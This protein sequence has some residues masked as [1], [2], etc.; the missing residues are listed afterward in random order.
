MNSD[1]EI[2]YKENNPNQFWRLF[3]SFKLDY[4]N[5]GSIYHPKILDYYFLRAA[6]N[7]YHLK[8]YS[9][10]FTFKDEPYSAFLGAEFTKNS[11]SNLNLFE[12]PCLAVDKNTISLNKKKK[13]KSF[14]EFIL[15]LNLKSFQIK[16]PE[17]E[18]KIPLLCEF[19]LSDTQ[20]EL[21]PYT[22]RIIDLRHNEID[23][24][25]TIRK[26][27]HSLINWGLNSMKI[28]IHD[29]SNIKWE[30]VQKFRNLH[31][32]EARR[33][34]RSIETWRKQFEATCEGIA[35]F[36]TGTFQ[37]ELVSAG[38][39]LCPEKI[40]YYGSS[41]SRRD[42]FDKPL[43]HAIIWTAILESKKRGSFLFNIG[44]TYESKINKTATSKEKNIAYF[45]EGFG[46][47]LIMNYIIESKNET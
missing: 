41:A 11:I 16:G 3:D 20:S 12:M 34:T 36:I 31:I 19:L 39:F 44:S 2:I 32:K 43:S 24:K 29:K 10:I 7:G 33:E 21:K 9:C 18:S 14:S 13:I 47:N 8:D 25:R 37:E 23:L 40:C 5:I 26:S 46:G 6:D 27:Y 42:L 4:P 35:F 30:T 17:L 45:K 28:Q 1:Y 38:Y 22:T 15:K